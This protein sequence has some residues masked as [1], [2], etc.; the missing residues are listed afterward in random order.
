[1]TTRSTVATSGRGTGRRAVSSLVWRRATATLVVVGIALGLVGTC[2]CALAGAN[3]CA[4]SSHS[5]KAPACCQKATDGLTLRSFHCCEAPE[6]SEL[7]VVTPPIVILGPPSALDV[8][9]ALPAHVS[10]L[11]AGGGVAPLPLPRSTTPPV[12]RI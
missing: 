6:G 9:G 8:S 1:V 3:A 10:T 12:L 11:R 4:G 5:T 2:P 7:G